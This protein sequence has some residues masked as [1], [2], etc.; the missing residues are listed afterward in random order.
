MAGILIL[1]I[2]L[3]NGRMKWDDRY[4][5][6]RLSNIRTFIELSLK[7]TKDNKK[8]II[9]VIIISFIANLFMYKTCLC[10]YN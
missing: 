10:F 2:F 6:N 3:N 7:L 4:Q 8:K 5:Y 9:K 1:L